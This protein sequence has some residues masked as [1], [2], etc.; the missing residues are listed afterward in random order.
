[1]KVLIAG[2]G[3]GGHLYPGIAVAEELT[4]RGHTVRFVGTA[5]GIEVKAVPAAGYALDLIEVAGLKGGGVIGLLRGLLR[6]P[7]ALV[8]SRAIVRRERPDLVVGV[9]GYASG[10]LVL[11]AALSG[12]PT[13]ILEQNS[14]PGITNRILG[15]VVRR[16]FGTFEAARR[17]FPADRYVLVGNP[18]RRRVREALVRS[19]AESSAS[20]DGAAP[21]SRLL[22]VG[23]SQGAHAVNELVVEA[24]RLLQARGQ[25]PPILHQTGERD[26]TDIARRYAEAGVVADVRAFIEDMGAAYHSARLAVTRAGA[27]TL[28]ELTALGVP[29]L[30]IP[31]PQAADDHQTV[32]ARELSDAGAARLLR[33]AATSAEQLADAISAL[34][35]DEKQLREMGAAARRLARPEAHLEVASALEALVPSKRALPVGASAG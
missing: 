19:S 35:S 2:G 15:R 9:G 10:P 8:Q 23:G 6:V 11:A 20:S 12:L 27:S 17:W 3:T 33:Q 7:G 21:A 28:S 18:V 14:V 1:V 24:M 34:F 13:A 22:V 25:A 4:A 5:R 30:L 32:N 16:V 31:F 29:A 26:Q